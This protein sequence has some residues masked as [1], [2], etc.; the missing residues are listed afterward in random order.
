MVD[1]ATHT[2]DTMTGPF[3][4]EKFEDGYEDAIREV[5]KRK[6]AGEKTIP[7]QRVK[8]TTINLD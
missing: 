6:Q 1:L 7:A 2:I 3:D 5:I 8:P 4:P